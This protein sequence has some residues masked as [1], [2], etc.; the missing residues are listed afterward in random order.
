MMWLP[1]KMRHDRKRATTRV[2]PTIIQTS[3]YFEDFLVATHGR[4]SFL[5]STIG[6]L[7]D[8]FILVFFIF[9]ALI[10]LEFARTFLPVLKWGSFF[11]L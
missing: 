3:R 6:Y 7:G 5:I 2:A 1:N 8:V 11:L 9:S 4:A 10:L